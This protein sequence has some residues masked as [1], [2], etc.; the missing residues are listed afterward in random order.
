MIEVVETE[1]KRFAA[2]LNL[3][4]AQKSQLKTA[5]ENAHER[6]EEIHQKNPSITR[7]DVVA[8][9]KENRTALRERVV[10]FL[11]PEQLTKW[12]AEVT[13]AR[14]FLGNKID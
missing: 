2:D 7:A 1:L 9:L 12:D 10:K 13:K 11:N 4:E 6:I 14:T 5:L 3:S 8:K